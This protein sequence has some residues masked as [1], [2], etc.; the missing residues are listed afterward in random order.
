MAQVVKNQTDPTYL[1]RQDANLGA[2]AAGSGGVTSKF[3][4][5]AAI[6]LFSLTTYLA[7]LGT[8]TYTANGT[9]TASGQQLSVITVVNTSTTGTSVAMSTTTYGPFITGGQGLSTAAVGG[10]NQFVLN[11]NTG[12][13]GYGG[14]PLPQGALVYCVSGTDTSAV[15]VCTLDYQVTAGAGC[16]Q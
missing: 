3:V 8:S 4:A 14:I 15:T 10:S 11:T 9:A 1:A 13:G 16:T 7:T 2:V 6:Q 12:T 5:F